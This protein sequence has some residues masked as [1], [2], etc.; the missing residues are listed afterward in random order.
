MQPSDCRADCA[1]HGPLQR[2]VHVRVW[3]RRGAPGVTATAADSARSGKSAGCSRLRLAPGMPGWAR[4]PPVPAACHLAASGYALRA[5]QQRLSGQVTPV[6]DDAPGFP[7]GCHCRREAIRSQHVMACMPVIGTCGL[8]GRGCGWWGGS[9]VGRANT[10][11]SRSAGILLQG[12][13]RRVSIRATG[14]VNGQ[15]ENLAGWL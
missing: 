5:G 12:I 15:S 1:R 9:C 13:F 10:C 6:V 7:A 4:G 14:S 2:L 3:G 11:G 8:K